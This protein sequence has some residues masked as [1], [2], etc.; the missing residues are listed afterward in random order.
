MGVTLAARLPWQQDHV[1]FWHGPA[2]NSAGRY[3]HRCFGGD[4]FQRFFM[5]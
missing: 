3:A 1:V 4:G 5:R 2:A